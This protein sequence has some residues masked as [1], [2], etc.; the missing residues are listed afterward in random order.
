MY[1]ALKDARPYRSLHGG[2]LWCCRLPISTSRFSERYNRSM[3]R[4]CLLCRFGKRTRIE[5]LVYYVDPYSS[6]QRG[7]NINVNGLLREFFLKGH[8]FAEVTDDEM[9]DAIPLLMTILEYVWF[10]R[11]LTNLS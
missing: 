6:W 1:M 9:A 2:S 11:P 7:S 10:G 4:I 5:S 3:E 8:D